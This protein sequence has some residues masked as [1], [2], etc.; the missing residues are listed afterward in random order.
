NQQ[1]AG[2]PAHVA[3]VPA[4]ALIIGELCGTP[5]D[6]HGIVAGDVITSVGGHKISSPKQL[7]SVMLEFKPGEAVKV[8]W[9]DVHGMTHTESLNL[10]QAPPR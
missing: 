10:V 4:G 3:P 5:A 2:V 9:S 8:T 7:T 6:K 1:G